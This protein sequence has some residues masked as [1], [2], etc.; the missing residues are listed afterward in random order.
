MLGMKNHFD[1]SGSIEIREVDIAGVE[2]I[3]LNYCPCMGGGQD[4]PAWT[5]CPP[6]PGGEDNQG[7]ASCPGGKINCYTGNFSLSIFTL[8]E[9]YDASSPPY[10]EF[11][12]NLHWWEAKHLTI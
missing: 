9:P 5:A 1:I 10:I 11:E 12:W 8:L 6:P 3:R 2:N 7:G 4:K